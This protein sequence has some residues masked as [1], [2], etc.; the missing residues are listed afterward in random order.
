MHKIK[1]EL[2]ELQN[3]INIKKLLKT[4]Y[5]LYKQ[6]STFEEAASLSFYTIF[7]IVPT[8]LVA[9]SLAINIDIFEPFLERLND[10]LA[11]NLLPINRK[12]IVAYIETS[13]ENSKQIGIM[14]VGF[15]VFS[16]IMFFLSYENTVNE[17]YN[18]EKRGLIASISTYFVLTFAF[19]VVL[20]F[21]FYVSDEV[22]VILH[23]FYIT[24]DIKIAPVLPYIFLWS[25][26]F[27]AYKIS[28]NTRVNTKAA[29][30]SSLIFV[31]IW[32]LAKNIFIYYTFYNKNYESL[33]GQLNIL[34]FFLLWIYVSWI[35]FIYGIK[36]CKLLDED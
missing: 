10:F 9:F 13:L 36:F 21:M 18:T 16:S 33:Y 3:K 24:Q 5:K 34:L 12:I 25:V 28:P 32:I 7:A 1:Q 30:V 4:L 35:I 14:G 23:N 22:G 8:I 27:V 15:V 2:L 20:I 19:P 11:Q 29:L 6:D 17:I 26:F 31:L